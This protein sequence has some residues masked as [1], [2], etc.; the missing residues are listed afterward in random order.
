MAPPAGRVSVTAMGSTVLLNGHLR[1][2]AERQEAERVAW[3]ALGVSRVGW[4]HYCC[5]VKRIPCTA[6]DDGAVATTR[7][8]AVHPLLSPGAVAV[9][10]V[11]P[12]LSRGRSMTEYSS[13]P[14]S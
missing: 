2:W 9:V 10:G 12:E 14:R 13:F 1:S 5:A 4:P 3:A 11:S 7:A 6:E 8:A